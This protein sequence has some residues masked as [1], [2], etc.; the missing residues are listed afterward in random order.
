MDLL[1]Q[2]LDFTLI[3]K[4]EGTIHR[5]KSSI[6]YPDHSNIE[7]R[8]R[9]GDTKDRHTGHPHSATP[10]SSPMRAKDGAETGTTLRPARRGTSE[11]TPECVIVP[12]GKRKAKEKG[13]NIRD[14]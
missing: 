7:R 5:L 11:P 12:R 6:S 14:P 9:D 1:L 2:S 3:L 4:G 10:L 13:L 8:N